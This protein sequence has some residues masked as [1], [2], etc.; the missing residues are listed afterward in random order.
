MSKRIK[1]FPKVWLYRK[2]ISLMHTFFTQ[3]INTPVAKYNPRVYGKIFQPYI[4]CGLSMQK[5]M[6]YLMG[7]YHYLQN[8]F[9]KDFIR[10]IY[11]DQSSNLRLGKIDYD[12]NK[13]LSVMLYKP[14]PGFMK[15][16]ELSLM[17]MDD[18]TQ[19]SVFSS[20]FIFNKENNIT[21][22]II[23]RIQGVPSRYEHGDV[24]IKELTKKMHGLR[25]SALIMFIFQCISSSLTI[26][27][28][29]AT[30]T[31]SHISRCSNLKRRNEFKMNYDQ[32]WEEFGGIKSSEQHYNLPVAYQPKA[33]TEIKSNKRAM[34]NRRFNMLN[35]LQSELMASLQK[36]SS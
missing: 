24:L 15:E 5:K 29:W 16:G 30:S 33:L 2:Q 14:S 18:A 28:I 9:S 25:P 36:L 7:H 35:Q 19:I 27:E 32:Y 13:T 31:E 22:I 10:I 4:F 21:R 23:G 1:T 12:E 26:N 34:Y 20:T 8:N 3:T 17:L 6:Q 11:L